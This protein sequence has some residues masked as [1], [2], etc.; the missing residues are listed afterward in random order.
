MV[1]KAHGSAHEGFD[2]F[3]SA[4]MKDGTLHIG[5]SDNQLRER[6]KELGIRKVKYFDDRNKQSYI[7]E[8]YPKPK[9]FNYVKTYIK[10]NSSKQETID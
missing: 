9:Q 1:S 5:L 2:S 7:E 8:A 10:N 4:K 3:I 6:L